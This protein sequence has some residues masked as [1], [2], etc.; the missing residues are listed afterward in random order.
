MG[1]TR[2][3]HRG[4]RPH[5]CDTIAGGRRHDQPSCPR[6]IGTSAR[7][8]YD[9]LSGYRNREQMTANPAEPA[10][11]EADPIL[12]TDRFVTHISTVPANA[13]KTVGLFVRER[14]AASTLAAPRPHV[15]LMVHGGFGPSIVAYDLRYRDYSFMGELARAGFDVFTMSHT[16]YAPSPRPL[17]PADRP[18]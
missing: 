1:R 17:R 8:H 7:V 4:R 12:T 13:G 5:E 11:Q 10:A 18:S 2:G 16:G 3:R 6:P 15:V 9:L 14:A